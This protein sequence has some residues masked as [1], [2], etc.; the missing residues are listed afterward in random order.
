MDA[1]KPKVVQM[2]KQDKQIKR[3][4]QNACT[5][6]SQN[7]ERADAHNRRD[8]WR[9]YVVLLAQSACQS[10]RLRIGDTDGLHDALVDTAGDHHVAINAA[11]LLADA[12]R[13]RDQCGLQHARAKRSGHH[14]ALLPGSRVLLCRQ[15]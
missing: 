3:Y 4:E 9:T 7:I 8:G 13:V 10:T 6:V 12:R 1:E 15:A 11:R 2:A 14:A 5:S